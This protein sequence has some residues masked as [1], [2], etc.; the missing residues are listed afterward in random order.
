MKVE[1]YELVFSTGRRESANEGIVGIDS[2][3]NISGGYDEG[4]YEGDFTQEERVELA[5]YMIR[6]WQ[7]FKRR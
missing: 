3:G 6:L 1:G 2:E 7:E 5:D 4:I